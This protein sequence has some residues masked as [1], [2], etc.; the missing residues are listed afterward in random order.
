L[1]HFNVAKM[2]I[3]DGFNPRENIL[4]GARLL[5]LLANEWQGDLVLTLASYN[6][7]SGA[8][9]K[10]GGVPPYR[11]TQGYVRRVLKHYRAYSAGRMKLYR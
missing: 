2:G 4:A 11:E 3:S 8:V 5:R 7:G 6:A 1:M 9:R 10:Y